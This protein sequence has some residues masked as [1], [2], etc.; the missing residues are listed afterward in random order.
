MIAISNG[1]AWRGNS[2]E[3]HLLLAPGWQC[4]VVHLIHYSTIT[5]SVPWKPRPFPCAVDESSPTHCT[6]ENA[7]KY[8]SFKRC[9][10]NNNPV[11]S[12]SSS[13]Q[14]CLWIHLLMDLLVHAASRTPPGSSG[15]REQVPWNL[16]SSMRVRKRFRERFRE[17]TAAP[18]LASL[19]LSPIWQTGSS[20]G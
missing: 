10:N 19:R 11:G 14:N 15:L 1:L 13:Q 9:G 17:Q 18:E 16:N 6:V 20:L 8:S 7:S 3:D 12:D 2:G 4:V 5:N